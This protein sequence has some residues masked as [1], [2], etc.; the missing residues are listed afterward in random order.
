EESG[1]RA[2]TISPTIPQKRCADVIVDVLEQ[3]GVDTVYGVPGGAISTIYD[4]L[5]DHRSIRVVHVRHETT[6]LFMA[7]GHT[8][9]QP[10]SLPC[11]LLTSGPGVTNAVTGLA[12]ALG[13]GVPVL[14]I[15]GEVPRV[16]FGRA[17]LQEGS[18]EGI[19]VVNIV[20]TVTR[21]AEHLS[22][23]SRA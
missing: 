8:R 19:D 4:A 14:V 18:A 22:I 6:A 2:R 9:V 13:E 15:G 17:A 7:I 3:A 21:S 20:R 11:V 10:G 12:A 1:V 23:P 16:K 5:I